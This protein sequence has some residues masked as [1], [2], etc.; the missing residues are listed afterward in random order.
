VE[1]TQEAQDCL[2]A[3]FR[4]VER[5]EGY[6]RLSS[7][8]D[9]IKYLIDIGGFYLYVP[10]MIPLSVLLLFRKVKWSSSSGI[11][12]A[13]PPEYEEEAAW[14]NWIHENINEGKSNPRESQYSLLCVVRWSRFNIVLFVVF[15]F[16]CFA[17]MSV[18]FG[19]VWSLNFEGHQGDLSGAWTVASFIITLAAGGFRTLCSCG[20]KL[21]YRSSNCSIGW[22]CRR[23]CL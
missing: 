23:F 13:N 17:A 15:P 2:A 21:T 10:C 12:V 4:C 5:W 14:T 7:F 1:T 8:L 11:R 20:F 16:L 3:L 6:Y 22:Y 19:I 9:T 18:V